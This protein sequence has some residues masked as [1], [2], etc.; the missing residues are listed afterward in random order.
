MSGF[1]LAEY[2]R[3]LD[4]IVANVAPEGEA[5]ERLQEEEYPHD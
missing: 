4:E 3:A 2:Q 1:N 5:A